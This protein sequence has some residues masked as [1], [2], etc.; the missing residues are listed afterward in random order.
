MPDYSNACIYKIVCKDEAIKDFYIGSTSNFKKRLYN[1]KLSCN[2]SNNGGYNYKIYQFIR[3]NGGWV[4]WEMKIIRDK[5][6]VDNK[7]DLI[8]IEGQYQK[9]LNPTLNKYVAGR[10]W[11]DY[12]KEYQKKNKDKLNKYQRERYALKKLTP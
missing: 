6:G 11:K 3:S 4:N 12:M 1:H 9:L 2:N 8:A 7:T 10:T 5:L